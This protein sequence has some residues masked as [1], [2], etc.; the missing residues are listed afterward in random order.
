[1]SQLFVQV[2]TPVASAEVP[3]TCEVTGSISVLA[4]RGPLVSK[5]VN[6]KFGDGGP[7]VAA[8]FLTATT[9]RCVGQLDPGQPPGSTVNIT[10]TAEGIIQFPLAPPATGTEEVAATT[11]LA[12]RIAYPLCPGNLPLVL[13]PVRLE[14]RF[15]TLANNVTELRVRV[16]PDKIHLDSHEPDLLPTENEWGTHYWEQDWRAGNDATARATAWRQLA[17]RFG[18]ARAAWIARLLQPTNA[19]P[20]TPTPSN[21]PLNPAPIYPAVTVVTDGKDS[22]WR[23][24]PQARLMPDRW[25][26]VLKSGATTIEV[27]GRDIARPLYVG[28]DPNPQP[29]PPPAPDDQLQVDPGMKWMVD[30]DEAEAKGMGLRITVPPA[31]LSVGLDSLFVFG[32]AGSLGGDTATQFANLLDAHHY[33]DGLEFLQFGTPTNNT[34]ERRAAATVDDPQH[35]RSYAIEVAADVTALD[36][37]SNAMRV[38]TALGL[39]S[40]APVLGRIGQAAARH[41]LDM[42]SMNAALW[43]VGWGYYL[44]NMVGFDGTGLTPAIL[45]WAR[46]HFVTNVRSGGPYPVLRCGRQPYG[47][48]PVTSLDWWKP[49]AGQELA[50]AADSWLRDL[51]MKL[52]N[53]IWRPR[54]GEAF[55]LGRRAP[56]APDADLA[57]LMRMDALASGYSARTMLGRHYLQHLRAFLGEDLAGNG[58]I[59]THDALAAGILQR[60]GIP[61]RPRLARTAGADT[62]WPVTAPLVQDG[63]VSP[64]RGLEPNYIAALLAQPSIAGLTQ[65]RP[66][67]AS[68]T[69][70]ASLLQ[71]L[72]RHA[73]LR[74]LA[75][76][77]AQVGATAP[78]AD[79][80]ALLRDAELIDLV[81]DPPQ[82]AP[83]PPW[84]RRLDQPAPGIAGSPTMRQYLEGLTTFDTP[85]TAS[86]GDF[87]RSLIYLKDRDSETLQ[88]LMQ[89]TLDLS[90]HR[91]DAWITSFAT[92]RLA[93][94]TTGPP[95]GA[96][97][98]AYGWVEKLRPTPAS[99]VTTVTAL[100]GGE[101]APLVSRNNDSGFIH[102]PSMTHA[103][104]AALLRN[105]HLGL[106]GAPTPDSPF[107]IDLSSRRARQAE[108]LLDGL[109]QGQPLG[110]LLGFKL[111]RGLHDIELDIA[112]APLRKLSPLAARPLDD[113]GGAIEAI[114]ANNVV[115]GRDLS[116][117]WQSSQ[118]TVI[119]FIN[120]TLPPTQPLTAA[121]VTGLTRELNALADAVDGLS[122][123]LLAEAA[124]QV[125]RGNTSR[126]ASALNAIAQGDAPPPELD[127]IRT[128]RTG[129]AL[130]HRLM[131]LF[132]GNPVVNPG[133][134]A[135]NSSARAGVEP[136][137]N[138]W[139]SKLLG[140]GTKIRCTVER[141]DDTTGA[142]V[143]TRTFP[144]SEVSVG[145]LDMIYGVESASSATQAD[146]SLSEVEQL[147]LY[148]AKRKTGGFD[149]QAT[150]RLHHAR[151]STLA[152]GETTLFD[153]LE[154]ARAVRRLLSSARG[155]DPEDLN[156]PERTGAGT[157]DLVDLEARVLRGENGLNASNNT[158]KALVAPTATTATAEALRTALMRMG[159]FG[160]GP[161]VPIVAAGESPAAIATLRM[162]ANALIKTSTARL[163]QVAAL[164][165]VTAA[166][167]P[168][169][170]RTQLIDRMR[171]VFG[172][173]FVTLPRF[174]CDAAG[175][176]ELS[177]A[178]TATK[179]TQGGDPLAAHGWFTQYARVRDPMSRMSACLRGAEVLGAGERLNLSVAQLPFVNGE[180]WVGL[181]PEPG[182]SLAPGKLSL[183]LQTPAPVNT[184]VALTGLLVDEWTE[185][186]PNT[187]ETTAVTFQF[188]PP[189]ACAPQCVLLAV[190]PVP[191]QD[192]TSDVLRQVLEE[193]LDLAKLR[194]IDAESLG[195]VAHYLPAL[196]L[197]FNAKDDAVSTDFAA[198]TH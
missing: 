128:P 160:I 69:A 127:V 30:F 62:A 28:P 56:S 195:E 157:I 136:M 103:A 163:E 82:P 165:L 173:N 188:D 25:I 185:T 47:V 142:V 189:D 116:A 5:S 37:Q 97:V 143:E 4:A 150:I 77:A 90:S 105:A 155:A 31:A 39:P 178:L 79:L 102:A 64:W 46:D 89:G 167:D 50:F 197:A 11:N 92:K 67:P 32:V 98:G 193:T 118:Q 125:A 80:G 141:L 2:A 42:R 86:L 51:L 53:N 139:A 126:V 60:L 83:P 76:A 59:A 158:L 149:P 45:A 49:P 194:A 63:E 81:T 101:A 108:Y 100:P 161:Y 147:V 107:A 110:A 1:M 34:D 164:R 22:A 131:V 166:T 9:W 65:A 111:E 133:W 8:T 61:W 130:T 96:Y 112:I 114:A 152:A 44:S 172:Q 54:L 179:Q 156:P 187:R 181:Q 144:L 26:A 29:P 20:T 115:D 36:A 73:L 17:D 99:S 55:R 106:T 146:G 119:N 93:T 24:A 23:H 88:Y 71:L 132:S 124:Y 91:L 15:F 27:A 180:R 138:A 21:Q 19:R 16:Y 140:N 184:A 191:G 87:R 70:T 183:V 14:T 52:R 148:Y 68:P 120:A 3:R 176:A 6:V 145:A 182:K 94:M 190:P 192:W 33:T 78:N 41:E 95:Q 66:D 137:L 129:T 135:T 196:Y 174:T 113:G 12:V 109:R 58:F 40:I 74:E 7:V 38:G 18:A 72:L 122:D 171:N 13:L 177:S 57:D 35:E 151:P 153:T 121:Q 162:Q 198:L 170:R 175:A 169:A 186:V 48:L 154:Q 84:T 123:A 134:L 75:D 10:V 168:G 43:Q 104:T 159:Q 117:K 85:A